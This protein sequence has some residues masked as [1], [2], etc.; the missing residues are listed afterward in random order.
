MVIIFY[1]LVFFGDVG[2][3]VVGDFWGLGIGLGLFE[4][5][6]LICFIYW[7]RR[8]GF[9]YLGYILVLLLWFYLC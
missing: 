6:F 8:L 3:W 5:V 1:C 2:V 9:V 4:Y 7:V